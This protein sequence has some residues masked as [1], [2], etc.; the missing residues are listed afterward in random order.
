M[1]R[2]DIFGILLFLAIFLMLGPLDGTSMHS[3]GTRSLTF[4]VVSS[5]YFWLVLEAPAAKIQ[6]YATFIQ[7]SLGISAALALVSSWSSSLS[8]YLGA[9]FFGVVLAVLTNLYAR[10]VVGS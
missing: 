9:V 7:F 2:Y 4:L 1:S 6:K 5:S 10:R 8:A 3:K